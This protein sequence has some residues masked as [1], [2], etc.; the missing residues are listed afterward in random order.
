[1]RAASP[2]QTGELRIGS[3]RA[4]D[5]RSGEET[6]NAVEKAANQLRLVDLPPF[7]GVAVKAL[8]LVSKPESRLRDLHD[9][10]SMD[11]AFAAEILRLANSPLYGIRAEITSTLQAVMLLG[12]ERVKGLLLTLAVKAYIGQSLEAPI[13]KACWSHSLASATIAEELAA[14]SI[15]DKDAAYTAALIHDIGRLA[16]ALIKPE[17]YNQLR[18]KGLLDAASIM[19][20]ERELFGMD[21]CQAGGLL[22]TKWNLPLAFIEVASYHH[23]PRKG[24]SLDLVGLVSVSCQIA[25]ALGFSVV[26]MIPGYEEILPDLPEDVRR[27]LPAKA[28]KLLRQIADK[29]NGIESAL[30]LKSI[31]VHPDSPAIA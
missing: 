1:M 11:Q 2:G 7:P 20:A 5:A 3:V 26:P 14:A 6:L 19:Q 30:E 21:H 27:I 29:M 17:G 8:Q 13:L 16:L 18:D 9:L 15:I 10:I 23:E 28:A 24:D 25:D 4:E 31:R 22:M 12:Y